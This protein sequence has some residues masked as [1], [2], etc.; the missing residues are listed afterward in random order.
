MRKKT[1]TAKKYLLLS[2][3]SVGIAGTLGAQTQQEPLLLT[4]D[5]ALEIAISENPTIKIAEK[6][7]EKQQY[8]KKEA[9]GNLLPTVGLIGQ[10]E[11]NF[12]I[13]IY[14]IGEMTVKMGRNNT[15]NGGIQASLPLS[16]GL[17]KAAQLSETGI[18]LALESAQESKI[19]LKNEVEKAF[20]LAL[21]TQ[22]V[23]AVLQK[24]MENAENNYR[25]AKSKYEQGVAAEYDKI[26]A[27]VQVSNLRPNL[28]DAENNVK[29]AEFQLKLLMGMPVTENVQAAGSLVD[30]ESEY[31][32]FNA[33]YS[34][35]LTNNSSLKQLDIQQQLLNKQLALQRTSYYPSLSLSWNY[36][37]RSMNDDFKFKDYQW[38]PASTL[39]LSV[40]VPIF[41]GF[42][43]KNKELQIKSSIESLTLQRDYVED[44]LDLQIKAALLSMQKAIEQLE[45]NKA[46][47][48][49]AEKAYSISQ[50]RYKSGMGTLLELNDTEM[51]MRQ[52][53]L[54]YNQSIYNFI[55]AKS[56]YNLLIGK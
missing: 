14:A 49:A 9:W 33:L 8:A 3:I 13:P 2:M 16:L 52:A 56:D 25:D 39:G 43:R 32:S 27:D 48:N 28:I 45:S 24:S 29:L 53:K 7:I 44:G 42:T 51:A 11:R 18:E 37:Y 40:N 19:K 34:Y 46:T 10:Y 1:K 35:T 30:Y 31:Q 6:E 55:S 23:Y 26:R 38:S 20:F 41:S 47:I 4:L 5:K 12:K 50:A 22:D 15:Y 17:L 21:L 36:L 54:N